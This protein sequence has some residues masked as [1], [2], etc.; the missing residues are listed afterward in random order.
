M[1]PS[2]IRKAMAAV[3]VTQSDV[4]RVCNVT[5]GMVSRV[6]NRS[7]T[8]GRVQVAIAA[9]IDKPVSKVFPEGSH[10]PKAKEKRREAL[11]RMEERVRLAS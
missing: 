6:I 10:D 3:P 5:A 1:S 8:S 9:A 11:A 2:E 7:T 4:S